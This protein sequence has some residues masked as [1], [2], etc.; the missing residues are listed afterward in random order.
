MVSSPLVELVRTKP[1]QLVLGTMIFGTGVAY[2]VN[3]VFVVSYAKKLGFSSTTMLVIL[4]VINVLSLPVLPVLGRMSDRIGRRPIMAVM[5]VLAIV[6]LSSSFGTIIFGGLT[7]FVAT[8]LLS[9]AHN[10]PWPIVVYVVFIEL[11]AL[12]AVLALRDR[13]GERLDDVHV[14]GDLSAEN[15]G[16][17]AVEST[18]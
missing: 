1:K 2:Y 9:L 15:S 8:W 10:R 12:G 5:V 16:T 11:I 7:P 13:R 3:T 14:A 4:L 18:V 17:P 6:S